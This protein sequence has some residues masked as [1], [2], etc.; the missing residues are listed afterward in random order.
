[1]TTT[2]FSSSISYYGDGTDP[3]F[4]FSNGDRLIVNA[5]V[6]LANLGYG[7]LVYAFQNGNIAATING[8]LLAA[9]PSAVIDCWYSALDLTLGSAGLID[10]WD[11]DAVRTGPASTVAN[12]GI[13]HAGTGFGVIVSGFAG[14]SAMVQNWGMIFGEQGAIEV[15]GFNGSATIVNH[16]VLKAGGLF[17]RV[18]GPGSNQA[19]Y[20]DADTTLV[21]NDGTILAGDEEGAGVMINSG[22]AT[23]DNSGTIRSDQYYGITSK[24]TDLTTFNIT[25][26]GTIGGA[27]GSLTL[28]LGAD[29]VTNNGQLEGRAV[30]GGGNDVFHG[31]NGRVAGEVWGQAGND[32]LVGGAF[33]DVLGG[34]SG[35][36]TVTGGGGADTLT[37]STGAD[38]LSGGTGNDVFRFATSGE[39]VGDAVIASGGAVAFAGVGVAWG[40][41]INV[42]AIDANTSLAGRQHFVFGTS[43]DR[44]HLWAVDVGDVTH[45]HGNTS[46]DATPEFDLAIND[47]AGV[48]ASDYSGIDFIL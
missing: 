21:T 16:G 9:S 3:L 20:S 6:T 28:A 48:D 33:A 8:T 29:T 4:T 36:D 2:V 34:G 17:D 19:V 13:I 25:N 12:H 15:T 39:S 23:I 26:D 31:E 46:G 10:A 47:G 44:G 43:H 38:L 14:G 32:L 45:I 11:G 27:E 42:S 41:L 37:G 5:G 18:S 40:D 22:I 24:F 1:M 30:L 35:G 7:D